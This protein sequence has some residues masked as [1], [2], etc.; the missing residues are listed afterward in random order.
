MKKRA[1]PKKSRTK[2]RIVF[3]FSCFVSLLYTVW[4]FLFT[5]PFHYGVIAFISGLL[6][7]LA[8]IS[9]LFDFMCSFWIMRSKKEYP[10]P[11]GRC[12]HCH[13]Q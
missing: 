7:F 9:G 8:E 5:I 3:E 4:R 6:L 2:T 11:E 13:L 12:I 10:L 1:R